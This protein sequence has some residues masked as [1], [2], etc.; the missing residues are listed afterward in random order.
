MIE[1]WQYVHVR[2]IAG[3]LRTPRSYGTH[4]TMVHLWDNWLLRSG[5]R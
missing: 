2:L 5:L 4:L 1:H 3:V